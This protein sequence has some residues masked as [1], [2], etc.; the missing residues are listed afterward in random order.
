M[1]NF[2]TLQKTKHHAEI[3]S[4][5]VKKNYNHLR[6]RFA[7]NKIDCFRLYDWDIP[8]VRAVVDWYK[9]RLVIAEYV[10]QQTSEDWLPQMAEAVARVL[11]VPEDNVF[12]K[13]RRTSVGEEPRYS[14]LASNGNRFIVNEWDLQFWVNVEDFLDTGL[15]GD[16]RETR[17]LVRKFVKGKD[18]LN[19]FAYTGAFTCAVAAAGAKSSVTV[20]RSETYLKW[21]QDNL[22]LNEF[23]G[24]QHVF[25]QSDIFQF[26]NNA[27]RSGNRFDIVFVDPPSFFQDKDAGKKFDVNKDHPMLLKKVLRVVVPGG[28]VF[29]STNHQRFEPR[30]KDLPVTFIKEITPQT[31]PEDYRNKKIHRCWRM[32]SI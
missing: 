21:A 9:G 14:K 13:H 17:V 10:R 3:L 6:R 15:Y 2:V 32:T 24:K 5:R 28:H 8:E 23:S 31:I 12:I 20:D 4:N 29:F 1:K 30:L 27:E 19:L 18:F 25:I 11:D 26:L 7:R 16:H 22:N